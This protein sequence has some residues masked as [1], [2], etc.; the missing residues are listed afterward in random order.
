MNELFILYGC[1]MSLMSIVCGVL[2][3]D[4]CETNMHYA[5]VIHG[6][7]VMMLIMQ[8]LVPCLY[9]ERI[10]YLL[11]F[12]LTSNAIYIIWALIYSI[13]RGCR[14]AAET[15]AIAVFAFGVGHMLVWVTFVIT[16]CCYFIYDDDI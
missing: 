12:A 1:A 4:P 14:D 9:V 13:A 15:D 11:M 5:I 16:Q 8:I 6:G 7:G 2:I 3:E 10:K